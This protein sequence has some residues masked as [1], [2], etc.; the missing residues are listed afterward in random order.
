MGQDMEVRGRS[1]GAGHGGKG[2]GRSCG[3]GHGGEGREMEGRSYGAGQELRG[4]AG[5][6]G[7]GRSYGAGQEAWG[8]P[9]P[10]IVLRLCD[11]EKP[12][13]G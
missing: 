12:E 2:Q 6:T 10:Y 8:I 3:A 13:K 1:C 7:Q 11:S 9:E 4:R 5:A